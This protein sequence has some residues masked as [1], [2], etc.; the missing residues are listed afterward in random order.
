MNNR[1]YVRSA[2][3]KGLHVQQTPH[4]VAGVQ[5]SGIPGSCFLGWLSR[6]G[7]VSGV[8]P[9][10]ASWVSDVSVEQSEAEGALF[11]HTLVFVCGAH[12]GRDLTKVGWDCF[13]PQILKEEAWTEVVASIFALKP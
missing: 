12:L 8:G 4:I 13:F 10:N 11:W 2:D 9:D 3:F 6:A 7:S 1:V 5:G